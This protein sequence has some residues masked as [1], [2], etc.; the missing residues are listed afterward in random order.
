[1][2]ACAGRRLA[3]LTRPARGP[4]RVGGVL[5]GLTW[6]SQQ[7]ECGGVVD[8]DARPSA[9]GAALSGAGS[10][11]GSADGGLAAGPGAVLGCDRGW[12]QFGGR[13]ARDRGVVRGG[14]ALVPTR[15][16]RE[17]QPWPVGVGP[18]P[19]LP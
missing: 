11:A 13:G 16:R 7:L 8:D 10:V 15:W 4:A 19:V 2:G 9:G 18:I 6:S 12:C 14:S 3:A 5:G 17:S 1:G